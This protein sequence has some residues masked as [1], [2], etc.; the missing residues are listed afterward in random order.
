MNWLR[1]FWRNFRKRLIN[2]YIRRNI[3]DTSQSKRIYLHKGTK[4]LTWLGDAPVIKVGPLF[5]KLF[6]A[7][8]VD[9]AVQRDLKIEGNKLIMADFVLFEGLSEDNLIKA[10]QGFLDTLQSCIGKYP[11]V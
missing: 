2:R 8:Q 4:S 10:R 11:N 9:Q 3:Y 6:T 7:H 1:R 5:D